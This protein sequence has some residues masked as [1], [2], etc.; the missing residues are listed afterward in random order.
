M[1]M[2]LAFP[3][4]FEF[5]KNKQRAELI[6]VVFPSY[7]SCITIFFFFTDVLVF[8]N[9]SFICNWILYTHTL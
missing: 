5:Q 7:S 4:I 8:A 6:P 1:M 9:R 3:L 2:K